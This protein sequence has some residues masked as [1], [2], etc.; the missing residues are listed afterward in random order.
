MPLTPS[1]E[2][3]RS[4]TP[5]P[6]APL[7]V[8]AAAV[9]GLGGALL[10]SLALCVCGARAVRVLQALR[11][12]VDEKRR[13][14]GEKS[15]AMRAEASRKAEELRRADEE[16]KGRRRELELIEVSP[17]HLRRSCPSGISV[18]VKKEKKAA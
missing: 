8:T 7:P 5:K 18:H 13:L 9:Y 6:T 15:A 14:R 1:P 3:T 16:A 17:K 2:P 12:E 11:A 10:L 4:P